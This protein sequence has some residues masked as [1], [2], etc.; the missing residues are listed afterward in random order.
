[1]TQFGPEME[2]TDFVSGIVP[3]SIFKKFVNP[4]NPQKIKL[5][6]EP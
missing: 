4:T 1:M 5:S 3:Q 6:R 2:I